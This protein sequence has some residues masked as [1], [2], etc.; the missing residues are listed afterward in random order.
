MTESDL[1][2]FPAFSAPLIEQILQQTGLI[3][4]DA[5]QVALPRS[6]AEV[7]DLIEFFSRVFGDL[8]FERPHVTPV[9]IRGKHFEAF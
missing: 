6:G 4:G 7:N 8:V 3:P 2:Q 5:L 1:N 9:I